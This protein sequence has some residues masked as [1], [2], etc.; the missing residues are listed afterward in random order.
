ML[1][2]KIIFVYF[3]FFSQL[4]RCQSCALDYFEVVVLQDLDTLGVDVVREEDS[5]NV[6]QT[7]FGFLF[8][9]V[10]YLLMNL[11]EFI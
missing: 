4:F 8:K 1:I 10:V 11:L 9:L 5:S 3:D 2:K 6:V 7:H